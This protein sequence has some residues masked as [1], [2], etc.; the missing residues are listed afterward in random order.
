MNKILLILVIVLM[1]FSCQQAKK[2]NIDNKE[3][4]IEKKYQAKAPPTQS[5]AAEAFKESDSTTFI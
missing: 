4:K 5:F 1:V 3:I 2:E